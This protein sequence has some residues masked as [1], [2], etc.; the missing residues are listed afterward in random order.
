MFTFGK[1]KGAITGFEA[2]PTYGN[3]SMY[4]LNRYHWTKIVTAIP[5]IKHSNIKTRMTRNPIS[6]NI[7]INCLIIISVKFLKY[8]SPE[9]RGSNIRKVLENIETFTRNIFNIKHPTGNNSTI[10][11]KSQYSKLSKVFTYYAIVK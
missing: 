6:Q 11:R 7:I 10:N 5:A 1:E 4:K 8:F 3:L 9:R 2:G